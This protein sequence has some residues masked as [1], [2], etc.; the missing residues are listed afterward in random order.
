MV[1]HV[2]GV[3]KPVRSSQPVPML[4]SPSFVSSVFAPLGLKSPASLD[5]KHGILGI[6]GAL[7]KSGFGHY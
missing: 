1:I 5:N 7:P 6:G 2:L 4:K 3:P